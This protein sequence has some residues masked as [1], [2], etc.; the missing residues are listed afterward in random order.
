MLVAGFVVER[1]GRVALT[2]EGGCGGPDCSGDCALRRAHITRL[3]F[4]SRTSVRAGEI[5]FTPPLAL[6]L[7][8]RARAALPSGRKRRGR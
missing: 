4:P 3:S 5:I 7:R 2:P 8:R 1:D 6:C